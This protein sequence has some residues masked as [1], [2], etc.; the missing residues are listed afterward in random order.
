MQ[1][2]RNVILAFSVTACAIVY[3]TGKSSSKLQQQ[4]K[5]DVLEHVFALH[6]KATAEDRI[7]N[8]RDIAQRSLS[9]NNKDSSSGSRNLFSIIGMM[10]GEL[11][12]DD[13][14]GPWADYTDFMTLYS[15]TRFNPRQYAGDDTEFLHYKDPTEQD[16][17]GT[18]TFPPT[19][20][21]IQLNSGGNTENPTP[22]PTRLTTQLPV[23]STTRLPT[24]LPTQLPV[25]LEPTEFGETRH[26][27]KLPTRFPTKLPTREPSKF[28]TREVRYCF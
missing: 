21:P 11:E 24:R 23:T 17:G 28:P 14:E 20:K 8:D 22:L 25:T 27:T 12:V 6:K 10:G 4:N 13:A 16:E 18:T 9:D 5:D 3:L 1:F 2:N 7:E 15:S 26:P 19:R